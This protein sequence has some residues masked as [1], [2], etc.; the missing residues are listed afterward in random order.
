MAGAAAA[1][2]ITILM[3][4]CFVGEGCLGYELINSSKKKKA[5]AR[6]L[7]GAL[8][9]SADKNGVNLTNYAAYGRKD[10]VHIPSRQQSVTSTHSLNEKSEP[11]LLSRL[12]S[13]T[14]KDSTYSSMSSGR[15][16][17]SSIKSMNTTSS[18]SQSPDL[19]SPD[20]ISPPALTFSLL[21]N[22]IPDS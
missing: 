12:S 21:A 9:G 11:S 20:K 5:Q 10:G 1:V 18:S 3:V 7:S 2:S 19:H 4:V 15:T 16:S 6:K 14:R 13:R 8:Y 22:I 17:P